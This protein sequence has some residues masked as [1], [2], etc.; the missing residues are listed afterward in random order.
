M[1]MLVNMLNVHI[2]SI[3]KGSVW[4]KIII[5]F[6]IMNNLLNKIFFCVCVLAMLNCLLSIKCCLCVVCCVLCKKDQTR[7]YFQLINLNISSFEWISL[8][9]HH[10]CCR[11]FML[12]NFANV[13]NNVVGT[14]YMFVTLQHTQD[15]F[16]IKSE[17]ND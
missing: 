6:F 5:Y 13:Y 8:F 17:W 12:L 7:N 16:D 9:L 15:M 4:R 3:L 14:S 11:F 10:S 2:Y 1:Y